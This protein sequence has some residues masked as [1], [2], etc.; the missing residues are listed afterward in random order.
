MKLYTKHF[1]IIIRLSCVYIMERRMMK[2]AGILL[3]DDIYSY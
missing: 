2:D 3:L 1:I